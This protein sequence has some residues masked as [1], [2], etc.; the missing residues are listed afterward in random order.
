M[1]KTFLLILLGGIFFPFIVLAANTYTIIDV[2]SATAYTVTYE[3]IIPCGRC[4]TVNPAAM[5]FIQGECGEEIGGVPVPVGTLINHKYVHCSLCHGFVMLDGIIDFALLK[6][7][8][9]LAALILII[10]GIAFYQAGASPEKFR[11][12]R[13]VFLSVII[14]LVII[15]TSWIVVSAVMDIVGIADWVGFGEGWFQIECE[16]TTRGW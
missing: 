11:W 13:S 3:G 10:S 16:I 15:Y 8:P 9:P 2:D 6:I 1:K 4:A 14:G 5:A 12:A 7:V